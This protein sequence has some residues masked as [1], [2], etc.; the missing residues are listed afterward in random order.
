MGQPRQHPLLSAK[1]LQETTLDTLIRGIALPFPG[2]TEGVRRSPAASMAAQAR[3][4]SRG[5]AVA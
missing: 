3:W 2:E 4:G 1:C 5:G